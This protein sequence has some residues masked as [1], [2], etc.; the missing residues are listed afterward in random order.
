MLSRFAQAAKMRALASAVLFFILNLIGLGLG[1]L[2]I[3]MVS[4]WLAPTYGVESLRWAFCI[5]FITGTISIYLYY[6][7]L[8]IYL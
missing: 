8:L 2:A 4:D 1:P 6:L 5:T 3:G 7:A